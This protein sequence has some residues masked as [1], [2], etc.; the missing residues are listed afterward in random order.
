MKRMTWTLLLALA[1]LAILPQTALAGQ[2][3]KPVYYNMGR[4]N[5]LPLS[6]VSADFNGDDNLD[7]AVADFGTGVIKILLGKGDGSFTF[8]KSFSVPSFVS[9]MAVGDFDGDHK[10]DIAVVENGG[11]GL[12]GLAVFLGNGDGTF[13]YSGFYQLG[14]VPLSAAVADFNG[15]GHLDIAVTNEGNKGNGNVMVFFGNGDG[16]FRKAAIYNLPAYP[17]SVAAGDLNGDGRPDLAVAEY[18]A[19][20]AVL[21]NNGAGK[22]GKPVL[23][24]V[25]P[26]NVTNVVIADL[27]HDNHPDLVV[28]T[29]EAVGVLLGKGGGKF[30]KTVLYST[31]SISQEGN[32]YAVAVA[33][34][35]GDGNLDIATV[36]DASSISGLFYGQGN[37]T[38]GPVVPIRLRKATEGQAIANGRY[39]N[40]RPPDL[41]ITISAGSQGGQVAVLLNDH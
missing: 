34:F 1:G 26:A 11:T 20:V 25:N 27:N 41:V 22:F 10:L 14:I 37:G 33:D 23:Y 18:N 3:K 8:G 2:F 32:P 12:G 36:V 40:D 29:F 30:G 6:I 31:K 16:T 13:K 39:D 4:R 35:N 15:D 19:G 21:L 5:D 17:Y 9:N 28:A 38:F 24:P 7:L